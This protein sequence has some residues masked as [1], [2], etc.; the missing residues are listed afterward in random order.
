MAELLTRRL[1]VDGLMYN[2]VQ[3]KILFLT[4]PPY[5]CPGAMRMDHVDTG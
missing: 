3:V 5:D 1:A 4:C 2:D